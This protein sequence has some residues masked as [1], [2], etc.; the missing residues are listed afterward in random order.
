MSRGDRILEI[1]AEW[2]DGLTTRLIAE[3][4]G[5]SVGNISSPLSKLVAYGS[6]KR[7]GTGLVTR[8][9]LPPVEQLKGN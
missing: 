5:T 6:L 9:Y 4:M 3:R 1:L 8:Y 7:S 2:P